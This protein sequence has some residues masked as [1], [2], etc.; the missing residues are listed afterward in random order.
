[1]ELHIGDAVLWRGILLMV[2]EIQENGTIVARSPTMQV[3][4]S[5]DRE[6]SLVGA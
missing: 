3:V 2:E 4:V 1:M 5:D 6:L